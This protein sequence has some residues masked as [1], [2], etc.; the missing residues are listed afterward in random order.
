MHIG[1]ASMFALSKLQRIIYRRINKFEKL[2]SEKY[3][4]EELVEFY[5]IDQNP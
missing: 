1:T 3:K 5:D 2:Q 4:S